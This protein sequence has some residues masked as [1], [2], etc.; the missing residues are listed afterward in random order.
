V[1]TQK[2]LTH[3]VAGLLRRGH[4][5]RADLQIRQRHRYV[6]LERE[7]VSDSAACRDL[8]VQ[9]FGVLVL[10]RWNVVY[11]RHLTGI[12]FTTGQSRVPSWTDRVLWKCN[13]FTHSD[14]VNLKYYSNV[15]E[16][17]DSDHRCV[18]VIDTLTVDR[19]KHRCRVCPELRSCSPRRPV[20]ARLEVSLRA[21]SSKSD[22]ESSELKSSAC[23]VQ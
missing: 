15:P 23:A 1:V 17:K 13:P 19:L 8:D 10:I 22:G 14:S 20:V 11:E 18:C 7:G 6:R 2:K 3:S 21:E 12:N 4:H 9:E 16:L 5:F